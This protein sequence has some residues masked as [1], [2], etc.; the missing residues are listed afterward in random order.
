MET[1]TCKDCRHYQ[2]GDWGVC[3]ATVPPWAEDG[4]GSNVQPDQYTSVQCP[5]FNSFD[6][7]AGDMADRPWPYPH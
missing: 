1:L 2:S 3:T 6:C 7:G 4:Y 5:L